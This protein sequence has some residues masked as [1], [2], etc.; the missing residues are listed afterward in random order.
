MKKWQT[1]S[2]GVIATYALVALFPRFDNVVNNP[3][4]VA[5]INRPVL[6]A[7]GGGNLEFPDN[8]LEAFYNAYSIDPKVMMETDVSL[9]KDGVI[10]LSHDTTLDRKT[11]LLNAEI[12]NTN[13]VDLV[14]NE[15]DFNYQNTVVPNSNGFNVSGEFKK[16][17]TWDK[18]EVTPLDVA[19]P[20]GVT[21]SHP[22]KFLVTTLEELITTFPSNFINVEI[23]QTGETGILAL[24]KVIELMERLNPD[25]NT[26]NRIVLASFHENV[27]AELARIRKEKHPSLMFSP[28]TN[29]VIKYFALHTLRLDVFYTDPVSVLQVPMWRYGLNLAT[30]GFVR[31][32]NRHN[33][34]V[35]YWTI[36]DADDMRLLI[37][38]GAH[39]IM[40]DRPTLL[41][42]I[43]DQETK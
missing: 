29:G 8:T 19:Y 30:K 34:A 28:E 10:I 7:H 1:Y 24:N 3:L 38:N 32:A 25:Y 37:K 9:T 20:A 31:T 33:I 39:G 16:Y 4:V 21:P 41:K 42:E 22:T 5:G 23:K 26:F 12:I 27:T 35:H 2:L 15:V 6:I 13:Y 18:R 14:A 11:N 17:T 40:T 43:I 36:N